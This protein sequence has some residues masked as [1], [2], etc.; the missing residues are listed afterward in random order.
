ML[1]A[2]WFA[3]GGKHLTSLGLSVED[4]SFLL[5]PIGSLGQGNSLDFFFDNLNDSKALFDHDPQQLQADMDSQALTAQYALS[6]ETKVQQ[7]VQHGAKM[8][9]RTLSK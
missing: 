5:G 2:K 9:F 7:I 8:G 6:T 4:R 3:L 1:G